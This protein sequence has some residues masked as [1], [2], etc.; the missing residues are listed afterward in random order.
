MEGKKLIVIDGLPYT[1]PY[2]YSWIGSDVFIIFDE[3]LRS[4]NEDL[5]LTA[6]QTAFV[7]SEIAKELRNEM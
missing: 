6:E 2:Y 5:V 4:R 7:T 3:T 1:V